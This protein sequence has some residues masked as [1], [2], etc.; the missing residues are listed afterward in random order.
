M[1]T[2]WDA[3]TAR[4]DDDVLLLAFGYLRAA[5]VL[6]LTTSSASVVA[7]LAGEAI[8]A[9][10]NGGARQEDG[11]RPTVAQRFA[12]AQLGNSAA[13]AAGHG[14]RPQSS[15][16]PA[17]PTTATAA[18]VRPLAALRAL[19]S[20]VP[21]AEAFRLAT[22]LAA[23]EQQPPLGAGAPSGAPPTAST[24][25]AETATPVN[26]ADGRD[27]I[28]SGAGSGGGSAVAEGTACR[29]LDALLRS[30]LLRLQKRGDC[31]VPA[32]IADAALTSLIRS[33]E[34]AASIITL[35]AAKAMRQLERE[36]DESV[37]DGR[38]ATNGAYEAIA[39]LRSAAEFL[40]NRLDV[41]PAPAASSQVAAARR[42]LDFALA[43][44]DETI[45]GYTKEGYVL[46][47]PSLVRGFRKCVLPYRHWWI[48]LERGHALGW[49]VPW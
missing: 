14:A 32:A 42:E 46:S 37:D 28:G 38:V 17:C 35:A 3:F 4:A 15:A 5:Q 23:A 9:P 39:P 27:S 10:G 44:F 49:A 1:V 18:T 31:G 22:V 7:R 48:F 41:A 24:G 34:S 30:E 19:A 12:A 2:A 36:L 47:C 29:F 16:A 13:A 11:E 26:N 21:A 40:R 20:T 33:S 45:A 25:A 8:G 43:S 6:T